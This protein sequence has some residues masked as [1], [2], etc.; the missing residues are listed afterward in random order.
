M[1]N[2]TAKVSPERSPTAEDLTSIYFVLH[3]DEKALSTSDSFNLL[4]VT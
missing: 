3:P 4:L 2:I 1:K